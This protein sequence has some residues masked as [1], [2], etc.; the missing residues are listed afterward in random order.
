MNRVAITGMGM[1]APAGVTVAENWD[2]LV[3]GRSAIG[4]L[5]CDRLELLQTRI[6]AQVRD[7]DPSRWMPARQA[8]TM[9]RFSQMAVAAALDSL[10]D[11]G[12]APHDAMVERAAVIIGIGVGG[13]LTL[14]DAF[15]RFYGERKSRAH[16]LTIPKLMAN[17][18][19]SQVSMVTGAQGVTYA[20]ASA[21]ASGAHAMGNAAQLIRH[22]VTSVALAGGT[23]A[24]LSAGTVLGWEAL[25]VLAT[26]TC[27]PFSA[28][29]S[30]LVLGEGA[31]V[32][33]LEAWDHAVARGADIHAE[34][35]GYGAT[36]DARDLTTPDAAGA[37]RAMQN[38][39]ADAGVPLDRIG[40]VNAHGTGTMINDRTEAQVLRSLFGEGR[41]PPVSSSKGVLGHGLG[42]AGALEAAAT[43]MALKHG[44]L[45]PTANCDKPD[46]TLGIDMIPGDARDATVDV[47]LSNSFAF[48]GLNAV[49]ALARV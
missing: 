23:E 48:G 31:A 28:N 8:A 33:V 25:R 37:L 38:A 42:T 43:V 18:A 26:D 20:L 45:P 47:A 40:Y 29:R 46:A 17:A 10:A 41:V 6:A 2:A 15:Y 3:A 36:A 30:G 16:P 7:F 22:G 14:D 13:L 24:C 49:L 5:E 27:R 1:I 34:L 4:A 11:A 32:F 9:D 19:P 44:V 39:V 21:C 35:I 12:L